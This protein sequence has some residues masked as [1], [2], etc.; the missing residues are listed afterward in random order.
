MTDPSDANEDAYYASRATPARTAEDER[1]D[2]ERWHEARMAE[3]WGKA[4]RW[5]MAGILF[6]S[7]VLGWVFRWQPIE[8]HPALGRGSIVLLHRWTGEVRWVTDS[9]W[10]PLT[11]EK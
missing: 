4:F 5:L 11:Q 6:A 3:L 10:V 2:R 9:G 7:V 8:V 1:D